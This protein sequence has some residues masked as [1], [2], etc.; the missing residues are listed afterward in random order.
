MGLFGPFVYKNKKKKNFWL[1]LRIRGK[2]KLYYFSNNPKDALGSLPKGFEVFED[3]ESGLPF[4]KKKNSGLF[5]L[6]GK[7]KREKTEDLKGA[8]KEK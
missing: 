2:T 6:K 3:P 5:G 1:H 7:V 8:A 4:L